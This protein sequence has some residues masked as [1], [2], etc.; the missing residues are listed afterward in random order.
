MVKKLVIVAVV[1]GGAMA[2]L[3]NSHAG[4]HVKRAFDWAKDEVSESV[5]IEYQLEQAEEMIHEIEPELNRAQRN[6]IEEQV[7]LESL[8]RDIAALETRQ[9][10]QALAIQAR[11][12]ELKAGEVTFV[13]AG[14]AYT[15]DSMSHR[16]AR[17]LERHKRDAALLVQKRA[18]RE[19]RIQALEA[20]EMRVESIRSERANLNVAVEELRAQLRQAQALEAVGTHSHLD[21]GRLSDAK[22]LLDE[23]RNRIDVMRKMLEVREPT[24]D[25]LPIEE[26]EPQG[27]VTDQVDRYFQ[28]TRTE[29][30]SVPMT[31]VIVH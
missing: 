31:P 13:V 23:C 21:Q 19:A 24:I 6:I 30:C 18:L 26:S 7:A 8:D 11:S 1:I 16:V 27:D 17:A 15:R 22:N 5:P 9:D 14:R 3:H 12:E 20:A 29:N 2:V 28:G 10:R 4:W 25:L